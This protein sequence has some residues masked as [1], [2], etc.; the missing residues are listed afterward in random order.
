VALRRRAAVSRSPQ[1]ATGQSS[2]CRLGWPTSQTARPGRSVT[3]P[4]CLTAMVPVMVPWFALS[5][6]GGP[7]LR[8]GGPISAPPLWQPRWASAVPRRSPHGRGNRGGPPAVTRASSHC[9]AAIVAATAVR[10][11]ALRRG[12][13][14]SQPVTPPLCLIAPLWQPRSA[15]T[16]PQH[17]TASPGCSPRV[18]RPDEVNMHRYPMSLTNSEC[19]ASALANSDTCPRPTTAIY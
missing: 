15:G 6:N 17:S 11:V 9:S 1:S 5:A 19:Q 18:V 13:T 10:A 8:R 14:V 3:P 2:W 4:R 7:P 12:V 16:P